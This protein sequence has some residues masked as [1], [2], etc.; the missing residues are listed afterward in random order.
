MVGKQGYSAVQSERSPGKTPDKSRNGTQTSRN[1]K[2]QSSENRA[3]VVGQR[4]RPDRF[5]R[6][7]EADA[8][9]SHE[10]AAKNSIVDIILIEEVSN[11]Y[12]HHP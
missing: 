7:E 8:L 10:M 6:G 9:S 1:G 12:L 3:T 4:R 2:D 5:P 11:G